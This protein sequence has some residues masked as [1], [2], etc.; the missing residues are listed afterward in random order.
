MFYLAVSPRSTSSLC[1][2]KPTLVDDSSLSL[3]KT[4]G[5]AVG[6][7]DAL[8]RARHGSLPYLEITGFESIDELV[9]GL[10]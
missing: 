3:A 8:Y 1:P 7:L 9:D 4:S 5:A 2:R 10:R 6:V